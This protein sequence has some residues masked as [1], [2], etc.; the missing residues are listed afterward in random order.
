[1]KI[2]FFGTPQLAAETL[3]SLISSPETQII[4]VI[5]QPDKPIGRKQILTPPEVKQLAQQ[6]N[7]PVH[8]PTTKQ[9]LTKITSQ[10]DADFFIVMAYG[11]ILPQDV[12]NAPK[13]DTINI[14]VSLLPKHRGASPIQ[15]SILEN[16]QET[17]ITI[18][19]IAPKM[20]AGPIYKQFKTAITPTD[21]QET[22]SAKL[23]QLSQKNLVETLKEIQN[24][25]IKPLE[26]NESEATYCHKIAK[27]DG[28]ITPTN[29]SSQILQMIKA[30]TP[31]PGSYFFWNQ[32]K[33]TITKATTSPEKPSK[34]L[35]THNKQ[36]LLKTADGSI[37]IQELQPAGKKNM[38][39][40]DFI[41]GNRN[42]LE[43]NTK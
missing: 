14:H 21:T 30:Y 29:T 8:Q 38:T 15:N 5:S 24:N 41:N 35:S 3:E 9:E 31:W 13:I 28:Q 23:S 16:D 10:L 1:M 40:K 26:Q 20:D 25:Q 39:A 33:I 34:E 18:M 43:A 12:I 27:Q 32:Q 11:M 6:H 42:Q 19:Q 22:L 2:V 36:L 37:E 7:I 17:G 4:A